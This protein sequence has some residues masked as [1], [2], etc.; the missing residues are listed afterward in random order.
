MIDVR[1]RKALCTG[2]AVAAV[3]L[4]VT[5]CVSG[6]ADPAETS[7]A[8]DVADEYSGDPLPEIP[9]EEVSIAGSP[10]YAETDRSA[11][12]GIAAGRMLA[13]RPGDVNV[14]MLDA[15]DTESGELAWDITTGEA[16][17]LVQDAGFG[18]GRVE[19]AAGSL[20]RQGDLYVAPLFSNA[21]ASTP[22][23]SGLI[24][25]KAADASVA[26]TADLSPHLGDD[27]DGISV[28]ADVVDVSSDTVIAN[29]EAQNTEGETVTVGIALDAS[30]GEVR[31]AE[32]GVVLASIAGDVITAIRTANPGD[33]HGTLVGITASSG[34]EAWSAGD[35]EG[36]WIGGIG[37]VVAAWTPEAALFASSTGALVDAG[38][39]LSEPVAG[40]DFVAWLNPDAETLV[41]YAAGDERSWP[42]AEQVAADDVVAIDDEGYLWLASGA[43][44]TAHD[45]TGAARTDPL[46]GAFAGA[47]DGSVVTVEEDGTVHLWGAA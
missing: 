8:P 24:A 42:G 16:A 17:Q 9:L 5:G 15:Y 47:R 45:R 37:A 38:S 4:S 12:E 39:I 28:H 41:T 29:V 35:A 21:T 44:V 25:I 1:I 3:A 34:D 46:P 40:A 33:D 20:Q 31:W 32:R 18:A 14:I 26:W 7:L 6:D 11:I 30:S 22:Y 19:F 2:A 10:T 27:V 23:R 13:T 36:Q 43:Q